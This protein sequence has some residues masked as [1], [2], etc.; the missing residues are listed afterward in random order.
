MSDLEDPRDAG[1]RPGVLERIQGALGHAVRRQV[2]RRSLTGHFDAALLRAWAEE[3]LAGRRLIVVSNRE[4]YSHVRTG[5]GLR[6]LRNPGGLVV[7]LD[8]VLRATGGVWV[9]HGSGNADPEHS[10]AAGR[11]AVPVDA[12]AYTLA[13]TWLSQEEQ[14]GYYSGFSNGALWPLCHVAYVRPRF[15]WSDWDHY[16][17]VN[18]KF[19]RAVLDVAGSD[20]AVVLLQD[21]HLGLCA[22]FIK[23]ERP[24]IPVGLFWHIPW[25]N[26]EIFRILPWKVPVLEGL[27]A[28]DLLG[29]HL[30]YHGM[31]FLDTV[32]AEL[33]ARVDLAR[34][35][36]ERR[37]HLT[38]VRAFPIST[39]IDGIAA[40]ADSPE[41]LRATARW[42]ERLGV[43]GHLVGLGVDRLD[44]TKGIPER[45]TALRRLFEKHPEWRGRLKFIQ[46]GVPSRVMLD[47]YRR[48]TERLDEQVRALNAEFGSPDDPVVHFLKGDFDFA[49]VI[50][51]YRLG[52]FAAVT[53][54]HDGMN[55]VAKEYVAARSDLGGAL[56][57]SPFT[58]AARELQE[59]VLVN[60]YDAD[61]LADAFHQVL[62]EP[63]E[64][65]R[66]RMAALRERLHR[67]TIYDW[68]KELLESIRRLGPRPQEER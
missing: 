46:L 49:E 56:I 4:P 50:A 21:Y 52:D 33:E 38:K 30:R 66:A 51:L 53:S 54:L 23:E 28:N 12:P 13:R 27:L 5:E 32:S 20:K 18:R 42:R 63:P 60:P 2:L 59:A 15:E 8:A 37:G 35:S 14:D 45:M 43:A 39:D 16:E 55:L 6:V 64:I 11:V 68:A 36:V 3:A 57:L 48:L 29:F 40:Q 61:A 26:P 17:A 10:D 41:C 67:H 25:P 19:A 31:N 65:S 58:G 34:M 44:Y 22:K 1:G 7:A 9:A 47:E 62:S 24:D